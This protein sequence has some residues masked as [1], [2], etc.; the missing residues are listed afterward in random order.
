MDRRE[1]L[2]V[3]DVA[4]VGCL[5]LAV[6]LA[7]RGGM[8]SNVFRPYLRALGRSAYEGPSRFEA[9]IGKLPGGNSAR[10]KREAWG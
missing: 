1:L 5:R 8:A 6:A 7:G 10:V 9:G 4:A 3:A 2:I